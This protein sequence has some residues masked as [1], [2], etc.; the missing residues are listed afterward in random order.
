[1]QRKKI[2][3]MVHAYQQSPSVNPW[4]ESVITAS[5]KTYH[6]AKMATLTQICHVMKLFIKLKYV[7]L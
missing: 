7:V 5:K 4:A 3:I 2:T 1:M 6:G